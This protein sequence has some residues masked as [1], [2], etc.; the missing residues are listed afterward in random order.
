MPWMIFSG[1]VVMKFK[2]N[3]IVLLAV[4]AAALAGCNLVGGDT[5][6]TVVL[7]PTQAVGF[8]FPTAV[9]PAQTAL[10][11]TP[12]TPAS[13]PTFP[14]VI[15]ATPK[16]TTPSATLPPAV[17]A[18]QQTGLKLTNI[19]MNDL[20]SGWAVGHIL[21]ATDELILRTSDSGKNWKKIT[22]P[23]PALSGKKAVA[24][25][26]DA[27]RAWVIYATQ[28]PTSAIPSQFTVWRTID[29]GSSW[30]SAS[31]NLTGLIGDYFTANQIAF[32]DANNGWLLAILGNGMNH[33]YIAVYKTADGGA[34]WNQ[35]ISPDKNNVSMACSKSG[36]WFRD[37]NHGY[38]AGNCYG[39]VKGLYLY[40]TADGGTTWKLVNL[41]GPAGLADA[42]TKDSVACGADTPH[43]F[44]TQKGS[45][46]VSCSDMNANKTYRWVY[47]TQDG[48]TSWNSAALPRNFGGY[49]FLNSDTG[50]YLGQTAADATNG[51]NVY[52]TSDGGKNWKQV[53]TTNWGGEMN[54][55][56]AK[57]GW[58]IA[59][60]GSELALV[61]TSDGGLT[62][63]LIT[64]LV[65]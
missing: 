50:W 40:S 21:P 56:D 7:P 47:Q 39:V 28:P 49:T 3:R 48:G 32:S 18:T 8:A 54:Y 33:T 2:L 12:L 65:P 45:V 5:P 36:V 27:S 17:G 30:K 53:S 20:S 37:A 9:T 55:I 10:P 58:I 26:L 16:P 52:T 51:V 34:S 63:Q 38:I 6:G 15:T 44:D 11:A 14:A 59:R 1:D 22:P 23:E 41:P 64:P 60:S 19:K 57:N 24:H 29:G 61:R 62:Y 25:F 4:L 35:I 43:F 13:T 31:T 42:Y 46:V